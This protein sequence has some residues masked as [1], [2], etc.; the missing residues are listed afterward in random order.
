[1]GYNRLSV[2]TVVTVVGNTL[3]QFT[4]HDDH[5][6]PGFPLPTPIGLASGLRSLRHSGVAPMPRQSSAQSRWKYATSQVKFRTPGRRTLLGVSWDADGARL[7][8]SGY[9]DKQA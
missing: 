7:I 6:A 4:I 5:A 2:R 1:M 8:E 9:H 3:G